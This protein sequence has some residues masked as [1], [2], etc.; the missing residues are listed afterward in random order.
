MSRLLFNLLALSIIIAPM[1]GCSDQEGVT[2]DI[3]ARIGASDISNTREG[4]QICALNNG[5]NT[6]IC[7]FKWS[8]KTASW[9]LHPLHEIDVNY[10]GSDEQVLYSESLQFRFSDTFLSKNHDTCYVIYPVRDN[11]RLDEV[12]YIEVV[13]S[14][15]SF[16]ISSRTRL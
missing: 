15:D 2:T 9:Y 1:F 11:I 4:L 14:G 7:A 16:S 5:P 10:I 13:F 3:S 12:T 8:D 6:F